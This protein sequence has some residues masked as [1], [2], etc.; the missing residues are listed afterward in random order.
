[1]KLLYIYIYIYIYIF[2]LVG[3]DVKL[4]ALGDEVAGTANI[5][6]YVHVYLS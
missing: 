4:V 3:S 2:R 5:I 1:M 6:L